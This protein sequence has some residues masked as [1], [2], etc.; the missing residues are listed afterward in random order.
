[1]R[2]LRQAV[3]VIL[4]AILLTALH[5]A[6]RQL[7]PGPFN[8]LHIIFLTVAWWLV[9]KAKKLMLL[10]ICVPLL[11][12]ELFSTA[13]FGVQTI[14][15]VGSAA[16][17]AWL[18]KVIV[19]NHPLFRVLTVGALG[20]ISYRAFLLVALIV[21]A[22]QGQSVVLAADTI[23]DIAWQALLTTGALGIIYLMAAARSTA[24]RPQYLGKT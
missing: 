6:V 18:L 21:A 5:V 20:I 1:M 7:L 24:L 22:P 14:T 10:A 12:S 4:G 8:H 2:L 13:P 17:V 9:T 11:L 15:L 19:T 16:V 3:F 23:A